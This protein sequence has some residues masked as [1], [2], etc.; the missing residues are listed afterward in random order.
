MTFE[1]RAKVNLTLE[2]FPRRDD[3]YH[4]LRSVVMPIS[5]ADTIEV[6][7]TDDGAITGGAGYEN[8]LTVVA[9]KVLREARVADGYAAAA[10]FGAQIAVTK[11][12]PVAGGLGGG[13]ADAAVVLRALNELWNFRFPV[14]RLVA[15]AAKVGSDVPALV[16]GGPVLME[17]RG[18]RVT[19]IDSGRR[20]DADHLDLVLVRPGVHSS[21]REV[22]AACVPR[23]RGDDS[24][25]DAMIAA[26]QAGDSAAIAAAL[27]NDLQAPACALHPEIAAALADVRD[28]GA[29]GVLMSGSGSCVFGITE[30]P[31]ASA[32][33]A[34]ALSRRGL[35]A[36]PVFAT[37]PKVNKP[38]RSQSSQRA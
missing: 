13:S 10:R 6:C 25:T 14:D 35:T 37:L 38:K 1:A 27:V 28:A 32:R 8:D 31:V 20:A 16:L 19:R 3:G 24:P 17:G 29:R 18:E 34:D 33:L 4:E 23:T 15:L 5:L 26:L 11:R 22:Y 21:T 30:S 12:I 2:V 7:V 9:A 36:E